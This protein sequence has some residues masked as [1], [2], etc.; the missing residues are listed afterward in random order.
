MTLLRTPEDSP[1]YDADRQRLGYVANYTRVFALNPDV[2]RAW[3]ALATAVRDG[4]D[5]R[6]YELATLAAARR[7]GSL[8][9]G[10]AH[11][12]ALRTKFFDADD[13]LAVTVDRHRSV[14][15]PAEVAVMD[16]A[17]TIAADP[18][19]VTGADLDGLRAHGLSDVDIF[20]VVA[21]VAARRFF[22][23][24]LAAA[25]AVPDDAYDALDPELR[26]ALAVPGTD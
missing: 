23:A 14:L 6:R 20:H 8:Y 26:A 19:A 11:A 18:A 12:A 24:V 25:H 15:E 16:F 4:M 21:A 2:Y 1:L 17:E 22:T 7:L 10:L 9:C 5:E 13:L 3:V